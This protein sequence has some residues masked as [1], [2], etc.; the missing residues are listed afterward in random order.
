MELEGGLPQLDSELAGLRARRD[1]LRQTASLRGARL[2]PTLEAALAELDAAIELLGKAESEGGDSR[3]GAP[4]AAW[5]AERRLLRA[6]FA[7]APVPLFQLGRDGT[8]RRANRSAGD[9]L[10][11]P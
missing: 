11:M 2:R 7:D 10:G 5:H 6:L 9:A 8:V 4:P 3:P 1:A